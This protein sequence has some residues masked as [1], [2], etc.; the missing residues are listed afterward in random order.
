MCGIAGVIGPERPS[1]D[2]IEA[3]LRALGR[4]GPDAEGTGE[5]ALGATFVTLIH[6]RLSI[7]DLDP[8]ANQPFEQDGLALC[9]NGEL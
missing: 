5:Y 1:P 4:R 7:I 6:T 9:Y 3:A 8:R 2:H